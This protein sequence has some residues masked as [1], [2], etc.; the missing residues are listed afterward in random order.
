MFLPL[1]TGDLEE[2]QSEKKAG[3]IDYIL[4]KNNHNHPDIFSH[5][6]EEVQSEY[7]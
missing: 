2:V 7:R 1:M 3:N 5:G 4:T 6:T